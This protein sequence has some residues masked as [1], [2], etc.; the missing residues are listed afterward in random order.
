M[1]GLTGVAARRTPF[2]ATLAIGGGL[3]LFPFFLESQL[4]LGQANLAIGGC[5]GLAMG[6]A[7]WGRLGSLGLVVALGTGAKLVP[8]IMFW[9]LLWGLRKRALV[10]AAA[11]GFTLLGITMVH[12]P[13]DRII[14]NVLE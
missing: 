4:A 12:V 6:L 10:V 5:F 7:A 9:P 14:S 2:A 1:A 11:V 3:A 8:A 13:I